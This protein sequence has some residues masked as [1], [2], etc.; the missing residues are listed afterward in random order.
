M[1]SLNADGGIIL[2]NFIQKVAFIVIFN[3]NSMADR[4]A[5]VSG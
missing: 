2:G 4:R 1:T 5:E 3:K